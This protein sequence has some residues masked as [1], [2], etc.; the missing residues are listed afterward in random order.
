MD[1]EEEFLSLV[2]AAE[3]NSEHPLAEAI[4]EGIKEKKLIYEVQNLKQFPDMV[5][6]QLSKEKRLLV[7]TRKL[8]KKYNFDI[9]A[10]L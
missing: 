10:V 7:G 6:K 1:D 8:M 4:V 9:E 5:L 2:G 3:K